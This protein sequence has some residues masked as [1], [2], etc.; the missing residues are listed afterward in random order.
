[1]ARG[2][3]RLLI[4]GSSGFIGMGVA[5]EAAR[6]GY[7][8]VGFDIVKPE[9]A[10]FEYVVGD[11]TDRNAVAKVFK[12]GIDHVI[13]LAA[14]TSTTEFE[15]DKKTVFDTNVTGFINVIDLAAR[16]GC[17]RFTYASSSAVYADSF[18]DTDMIDVSK[19]KLD[20]GRSKMIDEMI[21]DSYACRNR[22]MRVVGTRV[23]NA[24]GYGDHRKGKA[25][26]PVYKFIESRMKG[27][28]IRIFGDGKQR[29][30]FIYID[31]TSEITMDLFEKAE[32]GVYNIG[33]GVAT[34]YNDIAKYVGGP[35]ELVKNP[36]SDY[37]TYK[38]ADTRKLI[39]AVGN[40]KFT[41]IRE[42][43]EKTKALYG[44]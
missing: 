39:K 3:K 21:A 27:E 33:T 43:I 4:T 2:G 5:R 41:G 38:C 6:R 23:F 7:E 8:V 32:T 44:I 37:P 16:N 9:K 28:T 36:L 40:Y 15:I 20:Y 30:D 10:E 34:T 31:D 17:K 13:N 25:S 42:G 29:R 11:I 1:M 12:S 19:I 18:S 35:S 22:N 24:Y 26:S 14:I